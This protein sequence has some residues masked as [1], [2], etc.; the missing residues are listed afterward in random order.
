V[1]YRLLGPLEVLV[2]GRGLDLARGKTGAVLALLLLNANRVV[3]RG[4]LIDAVWP[5]E[6]ESARHSLEVH[7][8]RL[9]K[10][11]APAGDITSRGGGYRLEA[12][13]ESV[14]VTVFERLLESGQRDLDEHDYEAA[15]ANLTAGLALWRGRPLE[16]LE[17]YPFAETEAARLED[18]RLGGMEARFEAELALGRHHAVLGELRRLAAEHP[19]RE[20]LCCQLML[21]LYRAGRQADALAVYAG[22]RRHMAEELG[23]EPSGRLRNLE[24][25]ILRQDPVLD[26]PSAAEHRTGAHEIDEALPPPPR[27][28]PVR[29]RRWSLR[30]VVV[31]AVAIVL[32]LAAIA[33]AVDRLHGGG[34]EGAGGVGPAG[35]PRLTLVAQAVRPS[36]A[37]LQFTGIARTE[38]AYRPIVD[39]RFY[40]GTQ[41]RHQVLTPKLATVAPNGRYLLVFDPR[42]TPGVYTS[43]ARQ[44]WGG[45]QVRVLSPKVPF[46]VSPPAAGDAYGDLVIGRPAAGG[47]AS[48]PRFD[49]TGTD[50]PNP[51]AHLDFVQILVFAGPEMREHPVWRSGQ[52][53]VRPGG[54]WRLRFNG[55]LP[56]GQYTIFAKQTDAAGFATG[57]SRRVTF[58]WAG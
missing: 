18:A 27:P 35:N 43:E 24:Q 48:G 58:S 17:D 21:A 2:D 8:S 5:K 15:L 40:A 57:L 41:A 32:A 31:A 4:T 47:L 56:A 20:S 1:E 19:E 12:D 44:A 37:T 33:V 52:A 3:A 55:R 13:P 46:T 34:G 45:G 11:I 49:V 30:T 39:V 26:L 16:G 36:G 38:H 42:L 54:T 23:I 25:A 10:A 28:S 22:A 29:P 6:G 14:D 51:A 7:I 53:R 50:T 9:R